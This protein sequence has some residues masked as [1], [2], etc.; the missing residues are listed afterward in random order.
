[1]ACPSSDNLSELLIS[2]RRRLYDIKQ[3][4]S[5]SVR[6]RQIDIVDKDSLKRIQCSGLSRK[7][8]IVI[9]GCDRFVRIYFSVGGDGMPML[10]F[11]GEPRAHMELGVINDRIYD[12]YRLP[13]NDSSYLTFRHAR[14][15]SYAM[16]GIDVDT[17]SIGFFLHGKLSDISHRAELSI[18]VNNEP[19]LKLQGK[20]GKRRV[21]EYKEGG[22]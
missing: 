6:T 10:S 18:G 15:K 1:M 22:L 4:M 13:I 20:K 16:L 19:T 17:G 11:L 3:A 12:G 8:D 9:N 7:T 14:Q 21:V 5:K 2:L